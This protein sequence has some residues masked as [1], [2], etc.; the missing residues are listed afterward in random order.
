MSQNKIIFK[1]QHIYYFS[2]WLEQASN[3]GIEDAKLRVTAIVMVNGEGRFDPLM[4]II[5]H[6]V[7]SKAWPD[8]T[9]MKV[10]PNLHKH[11]GFGT[12]DG[13][14]LRN[15]SAELSLPE[16]KG[17][18]PVT[19]PRSASLASLNFCPPLKPIYSSSPICYW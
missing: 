2:F 18:A 14:E 5:K 16:A 1:I 7:S 9:G 11:P 4:I 13:W 8:Q 6:C 17:N 3:T 15:S 10:I 19:R 12:A